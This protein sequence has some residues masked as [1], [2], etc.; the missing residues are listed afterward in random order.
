VVQLKKLTSSGGDDP[1]KI[2]YQNDGVQEVVQRK[3]LKLRSPKYTLLSL[4]YKKV[5]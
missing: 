4:S 2:Y 3:S 5:R 1:R